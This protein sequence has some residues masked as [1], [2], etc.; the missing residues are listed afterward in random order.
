MQNIALNTAGADIA[1]ENKDKIVALLNKAVASGWKASFQYIL[2]SALVR[3]NEG[4]EI[5]EALA[6]HSLDDFKDVTS[7]VNR[8]IELEGKLILNFDDISKI[9]PDFQSPTNESSVEIVKQTLAT[10]KSAIELYKQ[11][12][13]LAKESGDNVTELFMTNILSGEVTNER[14]MQNLLEDLETSK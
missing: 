13:D 2:A 14:E 6:N 1:S 7:M 4:S 12:V 9:A 8:I 5:S 10:Q 11:I 3:G